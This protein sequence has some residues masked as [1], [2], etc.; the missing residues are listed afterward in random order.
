MEVVRILLRDLVVLRQRRVGNDHILILAQHAGGGFGPVFQ[1][2]IRS[3][4]GLVI[5]L[6]WMRLRGIA[7]TTPRNARLGGILGG[8]LFSILFGL[9]YAVWGIAVE[10]ALQ[11][12][13]FL[14]VYFFTTI[15]INA[16][17]RDLL[18]G[19]K[20]LVILFNPAAPG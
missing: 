4:G 9:V 20:P 12:R 2:G 5:I 6:L 15:G 8:L 3:V 16:S 14:L 13:D 1:A 11:A 19:G 10:F 7:I 18:A 17:V